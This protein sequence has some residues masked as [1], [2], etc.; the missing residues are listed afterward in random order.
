MNNGTTSALSGDEVSSKIE[1]FSEDTLQDNEELT[2]KEINAE[3]HWLSA[4]YERGA[5]SRRNTTSGLFCLLPSR[6]RKMQSCQSCDEDSCSTS[7]CRS[8]G[9]ILEGF[10]EINKRLDRLHL[11]GPRCRVSSGTIARRLFPRRQSWGEAS[12]LAV[13]EPSKESLTE[14]INVLENRMVHLEHKTTAAAD[15]QIKLQR[16]NAQLIQR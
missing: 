12:L 6:M 5:I 15:V 16:D 14:R 9:L 1:D 7:S 2:V 4:D 10:K 11:T 13:P 3:D 8:C